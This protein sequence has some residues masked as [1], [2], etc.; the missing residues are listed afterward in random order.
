MRAEFVGATQEYVV[1]S[2]GAGAEHW[3]GRRADDRGLLG[4]DGPEGGSEDLSVVEADAGDDCHAGTHDAGCVPAPAEADLEHG[5]L[6]LA[7]AEKPER[8]GREQLELREAGGRTER[9]VGSHLVGGHKRRFERKGE[10]SVGDR[11]AGDLDALVVALEVRARE[12]ARTQPLGFEE[13]GGEARR[14]GLA[15][16]AGHL[17]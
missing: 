16:R 11:I 8:C 6:D 17:H 2:V 13:R 15:V 9:R 4:S 5:D 14:R 7:L 3:R 12:Q 1:D 10:P